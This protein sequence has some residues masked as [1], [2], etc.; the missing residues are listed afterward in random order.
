MRLSDHEVNSHI[1]D[2]LQRVGGRHLCAVLG[3]Y[4]ALA[5]YE[6]RAF[7]EVRGPTNDKLA[8]PINVNRTL[9]ERIPDEELKPLVQN[10]ARRPEHVRKRL[11]D[12]LDQILAEALAKSAV[13]T[14]KH[15][16]LLFAY[17]LELSTLRT[18]AV[19]QKYILL[20]LPG[21]RSSDRITLF[22]EASPQWHR[23]LPR[24]L[25]PDDHLFEL[26]P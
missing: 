14:L 19:N 18:R 3:T 24:E 15:L 5:R 25:L 2:K 4:E 9:L 11:S 16:E 22:H 20:L 17:D 21:Q 13:V 8:A 10:E 26:N 6:Q 7:P 23:T 12:G 1:R